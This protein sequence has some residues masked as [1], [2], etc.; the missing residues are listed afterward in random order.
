VD[1]IALNKKEK[2]GALQKTQMKKDTS[3]NPLL[4]QPMVFNAFCSAPLS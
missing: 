3:A 1:D 4:G 2:R